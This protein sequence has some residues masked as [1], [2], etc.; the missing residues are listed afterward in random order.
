MK[1]QTKNKNTLP[2][3]LHQVVEHHGNWLCQSPPVPGRQPG[4]AKG[5]HHSHEQLSSERGESVGKDDR[6][7]LGGKK[8]NQNHGDTF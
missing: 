2:G 7:F 4:R 3:F 1:E 6:T 5:L 8:K